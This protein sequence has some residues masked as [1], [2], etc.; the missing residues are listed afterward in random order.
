MRH[1]ALP[2]MMALFLI[3]NVAVFAAEKAPGTDAAD[4]NAPAKAPETHEESIMDLDN[5]LGEIAVPDKA[6]E[7]FN[8]LYYRHKTELYQILNNNPYIIWQTLGLVGDSLPALRSM[9][10]NS[11]K[12]KLDGTTYSKA[13]NLYSEY[14]GLASPQ[15]AADLQKAKLYVDQRTKRAS[16]GSVVID[17]NE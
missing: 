13:N 3:F 5:L 2:I 7:I 14:F 11:G 16:S 12:L 4:M 15:L 10:K 1:R 9:A 8:D 17:L 6:A